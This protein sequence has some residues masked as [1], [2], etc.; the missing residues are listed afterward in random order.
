MK[1]LIF[2]LA[3]IFAVTAASAYTPPD[4]CLQMACPNDYDYLNNP[5]GTSNPD[6][7]MVDS[8]NNSPTYTKWFAKR[9]FYIQ[10][11]RYYYPFNFILKPYSKVR[12]SE[13]SQSKPELKQQL[14]QLESELGIIYFHGHEYEETDSV[15]LFNPVL[16]FSFEQNQNI[17]NIIDLFKDRIDSSL[18]VGYMNKVMILVNVKDENKEFNISFSFYPNPVND[19]LHIKSKNN[20]NNCKLSIYTLNGEKLLETEIKETIDISRLSSGIYYVVVNDMRY[21]FIKL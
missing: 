11:N 17:D 16:R 7:V 1:K 2:I 14:E 21:K 15:E 8:C 18:Y 6:S 20:I 3:A 10:F 13:I 9:Y 19:I 12:I 4:S 5:S